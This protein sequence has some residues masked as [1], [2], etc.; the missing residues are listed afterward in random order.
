MTVSLQ[1]NEL[2]EMRQQLLHFW[3][4]KTVAVMSK[5]LSLVGQVYCQTQVV[6]AEPIDLLSQIR[7]QRG[8]L[9]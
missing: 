6:A 8:Y 5:G 4:H 9:T 1:A 7:A 3:G 2:V